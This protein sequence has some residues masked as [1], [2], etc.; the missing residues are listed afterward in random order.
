MDLHRSGVA[1]NFAKMTPSRR[2]LSLPT[3]RVG[4]EPLVE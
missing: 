2:L 4:Q 3:L 1:L